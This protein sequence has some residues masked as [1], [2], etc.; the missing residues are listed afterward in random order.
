MKIDKTKLLQDI[1][2]M[3][4]K[5]ASMEEQL[6]EPEKIKHF[7]S[8]DDKYYSYTPMGK[9]A[10]NIAA[11]N[12]ILTNAYKTEKEAQK[13]YN[14]AIALEKV[15]RR[16]LEL[17]GDWKPTWEDYN[18]WDNYSHKYIIIYNYKCDRFEADNCIRT[19][20]PTLIP[21]IETKDIAET[22]INEMKDE[23]KVI[24]DI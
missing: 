14:K 5:L 4:E 16:L 18:F 12:V 10:C 7:P 17:Q 19:K 23:L 21:Y 8:K 22:I 1:E 20:Y 2:A 9:V 3:R 11:T 15:K 6:N 13:A 24:F